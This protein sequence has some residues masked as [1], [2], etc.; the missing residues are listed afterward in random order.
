MELNSSEEITCKWQNHTFIRNKYCFP[1]V[2]FVFAVLLKPPFS[3]VTF[4][5]LFHFNSLYP[6]CPKGICFWEEWGRA[7]RGGNKWRCIYGFFVLKTICLVE[8]VNLCKH[9]W[10]GSAEFINKRV[11]WGI[12][13]MSSHNVVVI[14]F[15]L[16]RLQL[17]QKTFCIWFVDIIFVTFHPF[18][19]TLLGHKIK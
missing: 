16:K 13:F 17:E 4:S 8:K 15:S 2:I 11:N 19:L 6:N 10:H 7:T 5:R 12:I 3:F 1:S 9:V 18:S 14:F